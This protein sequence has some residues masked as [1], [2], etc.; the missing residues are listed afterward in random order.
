[1]MRY[2]I[3]DCHFFHQRLNDSMDKRGFQDVD[4]MTEY[5]IEQWNSKVKRNDEVVILGD[6][7]WGRAVQ[8]AEVLERLNGK[9]FLITGN[10]DHF[11][12]EKNFDASKYFGWVE[13][14][15]ELSD[16]RRRVILSHY[17]IVC[18]NHQYRKNEEGQPITYMLHGHIHS[19]QDQAYIDTFVDFVSKQDHLRVDGTIEPTP[20]QIIN[21]FCMYSDY[22]PMSL[23]EWIEINKNR[24]K[25]ILKMI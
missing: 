15:K 11:L 4:E 21:C 24:D 18:Y 14:Y 13:P 17:P 20:C 9:K 23:D 16:N 8:T 25:K 6:F 5:M 22:I 19:T 1:M 2:Y 12:K 3:S 10:H 7:S